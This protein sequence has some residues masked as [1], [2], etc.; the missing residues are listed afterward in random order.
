MP[1]PMPM[2]RAGEAL[3]MLNVLAIAKDIA[4]HVRREGYGKITHNSK[5]SWRRFVMNRYYLRKSSKPY[6]SIYLS[7]SGEEETFTLA[8]VMKKLNI[9]ILDF[10]DYDKATSHCVFMRKLLL[11]FN[12]I[13]D[14]EQLLE[15]FKKR[16]VTEHTQNEFKLFELITKESRSG[17][18][19]VKIT[20]YTL[21]GVI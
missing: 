7:D 13:I 16:F 6:L 3:V 21:I 8:E 2:P 14:A 18:I 9:Q 11:E 20:N 15:A 1:M 4:L 10:F 19:I 17:H 5:P 12:I